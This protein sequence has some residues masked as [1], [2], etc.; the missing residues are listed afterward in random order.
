MSDKPLQVIG[1][2]PP[3]FTCAE[4]S[5]IAR[6]YYDLDVDAQLLV[7]ERDQNFR[8]TAEDGTA[9][10]LKVANAS[11]DP[12]VADFQ[13]R[14]LRHITAIKGAPSVPRVQLTIDGEDRLVVE[15][16]DA[17]HVVRLVSWL[18]GNQ[19]DPASLNAE[20]CGNLGAFLARLGQVLA[21][22]EHPGAAQPLLWD[23]RQA[24]ALRELLPAIRN[25]ELN[26]LVTQ[27]LDDF[28]CNAEPRL[29]NLRAQVIH[30]DFNPDNVLI[31]RQRPAVVAGVID[32]G[33]MQRAPLVI[34]VAV[35]AAYLRNSHGDPLQFIAGFVAGY[36]AV[37][38]LRETEIELL[39]DLISTRLATTIAILAWRSAARQA[40]DA[41]LDKTAASEDSAAPFLQRL[42]NL[43][44]D[45]VIRRLRAVCVPLAAPG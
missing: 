34:D 6:K 9:W 20:L 5:D 29:A 31:D 32:F 16:D 19:L 25:R 2:L 14:A 44:R 17:R 40:G 36:H 10:V 43:P 41:Y 15:K 22:F 35:A 23:M 24:P 11:E 30:N 28:V 1:E 33:D 12:R 18:D 4:A 37:T 26:Q 38:P 3:R 8:L 42:R 13:I 27:C 39:Y 45:D 7:S 21:G